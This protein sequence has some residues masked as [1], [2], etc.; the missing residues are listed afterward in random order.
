[1]LKKRIIWSLLSVILIL[2][3]FLT[4]CNAPAA[5]ETANE[6]TTE[7]TADEPTTEETADEATTEETA[8]EMTESVTLDYWL[9]Q[10]NQQPAYQQCADAFTAQNPNI[11]IAISQLNW[12][13]YWPN[14]QTSFASGTAPDVFTDHLAFYP[15]F[16]SKGQLLDIQPLVD[17]DNV[18]T[19]IYLPGLAD[20]W[21]RDGG[22]VRRVG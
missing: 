18:D 15:T 22:D 21:V 4:A 2:S 3:L 6:P 14:L 7:E 19:G 13:D 20:L 1:M 12:P 17:R 5:E 9:W 11:E 10:A 16:A 8:G